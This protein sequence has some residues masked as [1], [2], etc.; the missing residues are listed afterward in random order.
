MTGGVPAKLPVNKF[1]KD[2]CLF[3]GWN[4]AADGK[5]TNYGDGQSVNSI[6][7]DGEKVTLYAQWFNLGKADVAEPTNGEYIVKCKANETI[8]F[9]NLPA[10]T[11]Y[12]VTEIELPD[13]WTLRGTENDAGTILSAE[14]INVTATN[15]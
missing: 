10:G 7:G 9:P 15:K 8:V 12:T 5:G 2:N 6:G 14:R 11:H 3:V 13:G 1:V 4:T